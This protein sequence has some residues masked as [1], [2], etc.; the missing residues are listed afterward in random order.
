MHSAYAKGE[1][2]GKP[3]AANTPDHLLRVY[4]TYRLP[5][6]RWTIGGNVRAQSAISNSG[7]GYTIRQGSYTVVG[8]LAKYQVSRQAEIGLTVDNLFDRRYYSAVGDPWFLSLI[9]I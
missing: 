5:G 1:D 7:D 6:T 8:L 9:H 3:Y 4:T 2:K